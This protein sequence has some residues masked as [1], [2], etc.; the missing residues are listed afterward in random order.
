MLELFA[1]TFLIGIAVAA[2]VGAMAVLCID[3]TLHSGW[4][5]GMATGLGIATAD[6]VYGAVAAFGVTAVSDLLVSWQTPLRVVGGLA[7][8]YF[9][10]RSIVAKP[11]AAAPDGGPAAIGGGARFHAGLYGSAVGLT[12]TNPMTIIAFAAVFVSAGIAAASG[13]AE[14]AAATA[15]V[16]SG[17]LAWW[18]VLVT[19]TTLLRTGASPTARLWLSRVSGGVIAVFGLLAA[20]SP[21]FAR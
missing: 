1:R 5:A 12:L 14:A 2:P 11:P 9:G 17:S 20:A 13:V 3:R 10:A 4:R 16:A 19:G 6:A 21:L 7:L 18:S 8:V 15:G